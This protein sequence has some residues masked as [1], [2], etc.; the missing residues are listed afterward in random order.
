MLK[1]P[2]WPSPTRYWHS[3]LDWTPK[4]ID[5]AGTEHCDF[6][7]TGPTLVL[8]LGHSCLLNGMDSGAHQALYHI[9]PLKEYMEEKL[10]L[11]EVRNN[12]GKF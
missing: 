9:F 1:Q 10:I 4:Q 3:E 12:Q 11:G 8:C 2:Y 6:A 7:F 5:F